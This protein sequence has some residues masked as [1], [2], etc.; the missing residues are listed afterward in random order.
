MPY[1]SEDIWNGDETGLFWKMEPSRVLVRTPLSDHKKEKS[2]VI[3][4][5]IANATGIEKITL[6]FIHKYKSPCVMKNINYKN[7]S[8]YY[9]WNK[10]A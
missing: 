6:I 4:F 2:W 8:V 5:Y 10:K 7:L 1:N 3:I 9:F